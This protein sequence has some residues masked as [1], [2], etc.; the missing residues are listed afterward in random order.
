MASTVFNY[1]PSAVLDPNRGIPKLLTS[2][3][4]PTTEASEKV[5][6]KDAF[7]IKATLTKDSVGG[8]IPGV[9][10]DI[11]GLIWVAKADHRLLK[12]KGDLP[13]GADGNKGSVII[14]FTEFDKP[15]QIKAPQ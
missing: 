10:S 13:P 8:L 15:Y 14:N 11:Q 3:S 4:S 12:V 6:G 7:R 1:D 2:V 9:S 5:N